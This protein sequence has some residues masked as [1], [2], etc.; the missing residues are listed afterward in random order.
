M[1]SGFLKKKKQARLFQEQL[2][3]MQGQLSSKLE[4]IEAS[5]SAGNGLVEIILSGS[6][7]VKKLTIKK[8]CVDPE[9]IDGLTALLK[10]AFNEA[11]SKL[12][13]QMDSPE[14]GG[15]LDLSSLGLRF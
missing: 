8:E 7:E 4:Q 11:S 15:D 13:A 10:A 14:L 9:D 1:G 5:G 2:S 6:Y 12:K 3:Q